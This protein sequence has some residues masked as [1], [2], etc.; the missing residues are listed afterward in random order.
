MN[1]DLCSAEILMF[2][3]LRYLS[4]QYLAF[5]RNRNTGDEQTQ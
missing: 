1:N 3:S 5:R 2:T 4:I